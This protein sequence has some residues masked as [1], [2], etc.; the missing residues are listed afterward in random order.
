MDSKTRPTYMPVPVPEASKFIDLILLDFISAGK[1]QDEIKWT[2]R[3]VVL[4]P[5]IWATN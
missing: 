5:K 2:I 3:N 4:D 1:D